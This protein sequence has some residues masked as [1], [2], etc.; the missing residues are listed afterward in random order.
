M[1]HRK[2]RPTQESEV[3]RS[4]KTP[5]YKMRVVQSAKSYKRKEKH[6]KAQK[7]EPFYKVE[8]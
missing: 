6:G 3:K 1:T 5:Q 4:L 2:R 7:Y 8:A